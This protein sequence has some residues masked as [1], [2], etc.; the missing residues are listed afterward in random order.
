MAIDEIEDVDCVDFVRC[1]HPPKTIVLRA[2]HTKQRRRVEARWGKGTIRLTWTGEICS[3]CPLSYQLSQ[4]TILMASA[5]PAS[6]WA[7]M[8]S[9]SNPTW[10]SVEGDGLP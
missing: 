8:A 10:V 5:S 1:S 4:A 6:T 9:I 7:N 3:R 2:C